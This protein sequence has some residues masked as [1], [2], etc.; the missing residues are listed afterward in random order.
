M[1][2]SISLCN[3]TVIQSILNLYFFIS[4]P[5]LSLFYFQSPCNSRNRK[6]R[7][8]VVAADGLSKVRL[9]LFLFPSHRAQTLFRSSSFRS[10]YLIL[11]WLVSS[12]H[13]L[14]SFTTERRVPSTRSIC[15]HHSRWRTDSDHKVRQSRMP[16][17]SHCLF[18]FADNSILTVYLIHYSVIKKTLNPYWNDSFDM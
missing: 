7:I 12:F 17:D 5:S 10:L 8:T 11:I 18:L 2:H 15:Y 4:F 1:S 9:S 14:H 13:P 16:S 6:I 3:R